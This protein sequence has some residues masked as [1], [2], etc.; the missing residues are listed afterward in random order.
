MAHFYKKITRIFCSIKRDT[1]LCNQDDMKTTMIVMICRTLQRRF[2]LN[3]IFQ[4]IASL[5]LISH[6]F[7]FS[8]MNALFYVDKDLGIHI[9]K[10]VLKLRE[11]EMKKTTWGFLI[12]HQILIL[13]HI[14]GTFH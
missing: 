11:K 12:L 14:A 9:G 6:N 7:T 10:K 4:Q 2:V 5:F 1:Y 3:R 8:P 13:K